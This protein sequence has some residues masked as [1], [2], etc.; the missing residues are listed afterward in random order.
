MGVSCGDLLLG[1]LS[2][3]RLMCG[4]SAIRLVMLEGWDKAEKHGDRLQRNVQAKKVVRAQ[5]VL[6]IFDLCCEI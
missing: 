4:M 2:E 1:L 3:I 5:V 6:E